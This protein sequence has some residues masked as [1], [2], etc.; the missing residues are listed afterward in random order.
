M[1]MQTDYLD[2]VGREN[3]TVN[4]LFSFLGVRVERIDAQ[5]VTLA[6][7]LRP[8]FI[9]GGG[10]VA[11][12]ILAALADEAMAH[13]VLANLNPGESTATIEM[14]VRYLKSVREGTARAEARVVKRGRQVVTVEAEVKDGEG[15]L[16]AR[17][18]ASFQVLAATA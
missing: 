18:G 4:P 9:Q 2:E 10:V 14:N 7:P 5:A 3:Q 12:G 11:G 8:E 6:L 17:A 15:R 16:L 13:V 1:A